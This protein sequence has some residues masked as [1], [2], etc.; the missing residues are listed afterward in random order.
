MNA[1]LDGII[2][3]DFSRVLAGPL[4]TTILADLGATVIKVERPGSGD[5]TRSWGPP[6]TQTSSSYFESANRTKRSI[7]LNLGD[8]ADRKVA[9]ELVRRS[10]VMVENFLTGVLDRFGFGYEQAAAINEGLV[11][12]SITGFGSAGGSGLPGYDFIVQAMGGLMSITGSPDGEPTKVGVALVDVL[13]SK[14]AAIAIMA[15][16]AARERDGIGQHVEVNL[17]STLLGSLANQT[18]ATLMTGQSPERM[19]NEHPS[20]VPYQ[21][22]HTRDGLLAVACGNDGQFRR[23]VDALGIG[24]LA[25]D[26][27]FVTNADRVLA[28]PELVGLLEAALGQE[29]SAHWESVLSAVGVPVG[30]VGD[31]ASAIDRARELGLEPTVDVGPSNPPQIRHPAL[32]SRSTVVQ[33]SPPPLLG[34]HNDE[35]RAWLSTSG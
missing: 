6:W 9:L 5:D 19:G 4:A 33:P 23:L 10:D 7:E 13:T 1:A 17:L 20:I 12:C 11:Y 34:E 3:A 28:R 2:V 27:R 35:I 15:A 25:D 14:D 31:I 24:E 16:L 8:E 18:S 29:T 22:L 30:Q 26:R 32:Y 21:S